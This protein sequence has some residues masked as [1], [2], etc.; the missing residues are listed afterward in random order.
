[1]TV[2]KQ[3]FIKKKKK[4][5]KVLVVKDPPIGFHENSELH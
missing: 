2:G 5:H 4:E 1:M 3:K